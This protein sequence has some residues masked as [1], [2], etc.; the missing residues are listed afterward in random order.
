MRPSF[1]G[2]CGLVPRCVGEADDD[3]LLEAWSTFDDIFPRLVSF[4]RLDK[5]GLSVSWPD[6]RCCLFSALPRNA[7]AVLGAACGSRLLLAVVLRCERL[8][9]GPRLDHCCRHG[10]EMLLMDEGFGTTETGALSSRG[11]LIDRRLAKDKQDQRFEAGGYMVQQ[12]EKIT[13]SDEAENLMSF[14][15]AEGY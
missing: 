12:Q 8:G 9:V 11:V 3:G 14:K 5:L 2:I 7:S 6:F 4:K 13:S 1:V 10:R 15:T